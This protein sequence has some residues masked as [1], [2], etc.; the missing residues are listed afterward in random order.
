[1]DLPWTIVR[2]R[3]AV[4]SLEIDNPS[5]T[6]VREAD[7]TLNLPAG[8]GAASEPAPG[9]ID[10][11]RFVIRGLRVRYE[12]RPAGVLVDAREIDVNLERPAGSLLN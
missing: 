8:S 1:M 7:G 2:G 12:D 4:E 9:S 10:V 3:I 11:G 5:V 6:I